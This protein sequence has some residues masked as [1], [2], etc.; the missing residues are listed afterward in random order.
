[1]D[2]EKRLNINLG[3]KDEEIKMIKIKTLVTIHKASEK[4]TSPYEELEPDKGT[5][6]K[7]SLRALKKMIL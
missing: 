3:F 7:I 5:F 6:E 1:M 2:L 4:P